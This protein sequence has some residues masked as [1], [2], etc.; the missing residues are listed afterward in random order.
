MSHDRLLELLADRATEGLAPEQARELDR[1]LAE[2][3]EVDA[4]ALDL[5]AAALDNAIGGR[6]APAPAAVQARLAAAAEQWVGQDAAVI[7]RIAPA[8]T[9]SRAAMWS[10][11]LVAAACLAL[12]AVAWWSKLP[13]PSVEVQR[14][15]ML[16]RSG[17]A[18][19][20]LAPF[21]MP[22]SGEP[23]AIS[24]VTGDVVWDE[25]AQRG[26][27]RLIGLPPNDPAK[28]QYQIWLVDSRELSFRINGG[29]FD[30]KAS[31]E[32]I[33]PITP[34]LRTKGVGAVAV[35]VEP[36]GGVVVSDLTRRVVIASAR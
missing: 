21:N 30:A 22:G 31:G 19:L 10:G 34:E 32:L 8:P 3:P 5:A 16:A 4:D 18:T 27:L 1:L 7:A 25:G 17:V 11:W 29:V 14:Q 2:P 6:I 36:P 12:A 35:T 23:P 33:V 24:G 9:R 20:P 13:S 28:D 26:Y 15:A